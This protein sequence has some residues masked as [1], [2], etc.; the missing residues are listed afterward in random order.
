MDSS[1]HEKD[2]VP[3]TAELAEYGLAASVGLGM[4]IMALAPLAIPFIALTVLFALPLLLPVLA[5]ALIG[6]IIAAPVLL[7]RRRGRRL[8]HQDA[9][10]SGRPHQSLRASPF[11]AE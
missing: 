2:H 3:T 6:G 1:S 7:L 9:A 8:R 11:A 10:T 4:L 5:L